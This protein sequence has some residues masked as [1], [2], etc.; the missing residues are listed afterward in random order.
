MLFVFCFFFSLKEMKVTFPLAPSPSPGRGYSQHFFSPPRRAP[1][2]PPPCRGTADMA[3]RRRATCKSHANH[4][5]TDRRR[6]A[7]RHG[8]APLCKCDRRPPAARSGLLLSPPL[9]HRG[10]LTGCSPANDGARREVS[11][12]EA[13]R[14]RKRR[15][16][17]EEEG[18]EEGEAAAAAA[19]PRMLRLRCKARSGT[20]PL[21]GLTAH[22]RLRDMQAAL[23]ALTGVPVPAQRLLLG[24][25]PRSLDLSDGERRLGDLGIHS[26]E[27]PGALGLR[28][29]DEGRGG[30]RHFVASAAP[31]AAITVIK[32]GC[33]PARPSSAGCRAGSASRGLLSTARAR[34][35]LLLAGSAGGGFARV[36]GGPEVKSRGL[37][38]DGDGAGT[39][40]ASRPGPAAYARSASRG[41]TGCF[42]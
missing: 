38:G 10:A 3:P 18:E 29:G 42:G 25:P 6:T 22:S 31:P 36:A 32:R 37:E 40:Q 9:R 8:R 11:R 30:H 34:E 35:G 16:V 33:G 2:L 26:G 4:T 28:G 17:G 14:K 15:P 12:E 27:R 1:V 41:A 39:R 20:H 21:P 5:Q 24:F 13:G 23:A 7:L 19:P